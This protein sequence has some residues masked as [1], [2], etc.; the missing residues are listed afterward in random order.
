MSLS[1]IQSRLRLYF[2]KRILGCKGGLSTNA[3]RE[4]CLYLVADV[5]LPFLAEKKHLVLISPA[6]CTR[7]V[8]KEAGVMGGCF[9]L[10]DYCRVFYIE[11]PGEDEDRGRAAALLRTDTMERED[12]EEMKTLHALPTVLKHQNYV[13]IF[14]GKTKKCEKLSIWDHQF[15]V[16]PNKAPSKFYKAQ[17]CVFRNKLYITT[18]DQKPNLLQF[19]PETELFLSAGLSSITSKSPIL[20]SLSEEIIHFDSFFVCRWRV[21]SSGAEQQP[22]VIGNLLQICMSEGWALDRG[23]ED[24]FSI[25]LTCP[26]REG[27]RLYFLSAWSEEE[28][29]LT[30]FQEAQQRIESRVI[31]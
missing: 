30:V 27:Q 11:K 4:V 25:S 3:A 24:R 5:F 16:L 12:I 14:A 23:P 18:K 6:T 19:D 31:E 8:K 28:A 21:A 26:V 9:C 13:Y 7:K 2:I 10:L 29:R 20:I 22:P 17:G 15:T 1:S